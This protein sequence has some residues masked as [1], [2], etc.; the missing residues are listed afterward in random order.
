M[1]KQSLLFILLFVVFSGVLV[2]IYVKN[3]DSRATQR[4]LIETLSNLQIE[5]SVLSSI[6]DNR[7]H[8]FSR[9]GILLDKSHSVFDVEGKIHKL[10]EIIRENMLVFRYSMYNCNTCIEEQL[11]ILKNNRDS[12]DLSHI[13]LLV[14]YES[15]LQMSRH[16]K[17]NNIEFSIFNTGDELRNLIPDLGLPYYFVINENEMRINKMLIPMKETRSITEQ[18]MTS[19]K[20]N[21]FD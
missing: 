8:E 18:Y 4:K 15:Y 17:I 2:Y 11:E 6:A 20:H 9:N 5:Y 10:G 7:V 19:V 21:Y 14:D 13:V 12:L 3:M 1:K 16:A